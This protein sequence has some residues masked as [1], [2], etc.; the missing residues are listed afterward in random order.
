MVDIGLGI[1]STKLINLDK[2]IYDLIVSL[3]SKLQN[4]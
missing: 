3:E 1:H 2:H 4:N